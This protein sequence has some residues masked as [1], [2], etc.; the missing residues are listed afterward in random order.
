MS[1]AIPKWDV[2][3]FA[4]YPSSQLKMSL[5]VPNS[6]IYIVQEVQQYMTTVL[7]E[8]R[9]FE[10]I[11]ILKI[12]LE[13]DLSTLEKSYNN[14]P[15]QIVQRTFID[16]DQTFL[17]FLINIPRLAEVI[18]IEMT[19]LREKLNNLFKYIGQSASSNGEVFF[20][21]TSHDYGVFH[22]TPVTKTP[23]CFPL[24]K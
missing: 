1:T 24:F 15:Q 22:V 14:W 10:L 18:R 2:L 17:L 7:R 5:P 13:A 9:Q 21:F 11:P 6:Y 19:F 23:P 3:E 20:M 4:N 8:N 12:F 16:D